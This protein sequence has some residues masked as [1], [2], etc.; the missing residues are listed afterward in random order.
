M[1][2]RLFLDGVA[3]EGGDQ[4]VDQRVEGSGKALARAAPAG[5]AGRQ[6]TAPLAGEATHPVA[7]RFLQEGRVDET[8][9]S[10][11]LDSM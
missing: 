2:Q 10:H 3:G 5:L 7:G 4:A 9:I 6:L 8:R 11:D 1:V